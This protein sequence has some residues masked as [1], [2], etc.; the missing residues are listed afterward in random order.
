M[1]KLLFGIFMMLTVFSCATNTFEPEKGKPMGFNII[2]SKTAITRATELKNGDLTTLNVD[3][4]YADD[5][6]LFKNFEIT[7]NNGEWTHNQG[8]VYHPEVPLQHFSVLSADPTVALAYNNNNAVDFNY[9]AD[10]DEDLIG[11]YAISDDSDGLVNLVYKH[12]LSQVNFAMGTLTNGWELVYLNNISIQGIADQGDCNLSIA[13][14]LTWNNLEGDAIYNYNFETREPLML[15][16][17]DFNTNPDAYIQFDYYI[18]H[19]NSGK[20]D[21]DGTAK[22]YLNTLSIKEW[23]P[24]IKYLYVINFN[25]IIADAAIAEIHFNVSVDPWLDPEEIIQVN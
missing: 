1:K 19:D 18:K 17:Q 11:A 10:K 5:N 2:T 16:P 23:L 9:I 7:N 6:Q 24:G 3:S 8:I 13:N 25:N 21:L 12:L 22:V 15:M 14:N 20:R 4:Y